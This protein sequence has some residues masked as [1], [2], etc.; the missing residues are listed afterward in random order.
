M[1]EEGGLYNMAEPME[2][3]NYVLQFK[4]GSYVPKHESILKNI[5]TILLIAYALIYIIIYF[6]FGKSATKEIPFS[7]WICV[8]A[9]VIYR[10]SVGGFVMKPY[11][12]ELWFYDDYMVHCRVITYYSKNN[13]RKEYYKFY[14]KDVRQL[15]FRTPLY[16]VEIHG[17]TEAT[18]YKYNKD[19]TLNTVP[20]QN[21]T[22]DA[23]SSFYT[24]FNPE[25][26]FAKVF[27]TH[28][29]LKIEYQDA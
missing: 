13:V 29:P 20:Q 5:V 25:I 24:M 28:T 10:I 21:I 4:E 17:V 16:K 2:Q 8:V 12:S 3:P 6:A 1:N 27:E 7:V 19:G 11:P 9:G 18:F 14:Y 23:Y 15:L 26:D 22:C